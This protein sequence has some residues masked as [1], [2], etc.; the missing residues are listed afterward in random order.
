MM[1]CGVAAVGALACVPERAPAQCR[2][3]SNPTTLPDS[4]TNEAGIELSVSAT[5]DFDRLVLLGSGEGT[6]TLLPNGSRSANGSI[7]AISG[8]AMVGA[9]VVRGE[10]GRGVR[11]ELPSRIELHSMSGGRI[12][13][14][15]I[16]SDLPALP[17]LDS[18]GNLSFRFGGK[19]R[20]SGDA[21]GDYRGDVPITVQ[22][23]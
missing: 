2:L 7:A 12:A 11:V 10:A 5:L 23:L 1:W 3:C 19:L 20:L 13:I 8:G 21:E 9:V 4:K 18:A 22:Y 17:R 14:D 15:D 16:V 6:A